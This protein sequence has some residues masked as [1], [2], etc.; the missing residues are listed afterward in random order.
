MSKEIT[1]RNFVA[2]IAGL[3]GTAA[4]MA[5]L[6][7]MIAK[8][9]E[10]GVPE[11]WDY[12]Y[13]IVVCG[14]GGA[15]LLAALKA[16]D[17]GCKVLCIDANYDCGGHASVSYGITHSGGGTSAQK[18]QGIEDT[19]DQYY[20]DHTNPTAADSRFNNREII[21]ECADRMP[22]CFEWMLSHGMKL[23]GEVMR[24][25]GEGDC[26]TVA[27]SAFAD[28]TGYI[29]IYDGHVNQGEPSGVAV[30]RPFEE[31]ARKQGVDFM[32]NR[33][34]DALIQD[35]T[36]RVVGVRASYSPRF[37]KDGTQ[38][39][40]LHADENI[41]ETAE[42][43]V[44]HA[45]KAVVVA[46]GGGSGNVAYRTMFDPKWGVQM[47]G[48]AGEPYSFQDA[49]GEIAGL[50][51]GAGIDTA[52]SWTYLP[53]SSVIPSQRVGCRYTY[54]N[55]IWGEDA[56]LWEYV[57]AKGLL[58][59]DYNGVI[60]VN[61]L[62]KRFVNEDLGYAA[63]TGAAD[64]KDPS[65]GGSSK[66]VY[67]SSALG[68]VILNEGTGAAERVGGPIW[69]IFD[70]AYAQEQGYDLAYPN[71]D[72]ENGYFFKA[73]TIEELAEAIVN[74]Y[75]ED[76]KMDPA[77]LKETVDNYNAMC[78]A[79][80]DTEFGKAAE[81]LEKKIESGPFYAAWA[82][83]NMHDCL[84]GLRTNGHRQVLTCAGEPIEGLFACGECAGGH[85]T[86]GL[87]KAQTSGYI[88]GLYAAQA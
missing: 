7:P 24:G 66:D 64:S 58:L 67:T 47:D 34:M 75:Y 46:T 73:D 20:I 50:A 81:D 83:P 10:N 69:A 17:D 12:D 48:C 31:D 86:H 28:P 29:N 68:S 37:K 60:Q 85:R 53:T 8:A 52:G 15:G 51:I 38:L 74:K 84:S 32:M 40:G 78:D 16:C 1:R 70:D 9:S 88:A 11:N 18:A 59:T 62:G 44:I 6:E 21:R 22:E 63:G 41:D 49:S 42:E 54:V 2:G 33:H 76:V 4:S 61:M 72:E 5:A 87:G 57:G 3:A 14:A 82:T 25:L 77:T 19:P 26:D 55:L 13:D 71:I 45:A 27:R 79:G 39:K 56:D 36:G 80:E 43:I 23:G 35:E 30:T 65:A